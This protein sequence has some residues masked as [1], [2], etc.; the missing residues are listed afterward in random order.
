MEVT[1]DTNGTLL[2]KTEP[3]NPTRATGFKCTESQRHKWHTVA[4]NR[5]SKPCEGNRL[6]V[7]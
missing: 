4:Q 6:K 3:P 7:H 1:K 2:L 5:A